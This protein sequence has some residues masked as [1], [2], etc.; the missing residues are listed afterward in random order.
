[1]T[2]KIGFLVAILF[3]VAGR[4]DLYSQTSCYANELFDTA[5]VPNDIRLSDIDGDGDLDT[6]TLKEILWRLLTTS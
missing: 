3:A 2:H 6:T 1:M 4:G 5:N